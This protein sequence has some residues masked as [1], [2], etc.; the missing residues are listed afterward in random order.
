MPSTYEPIATTTLGSTATT[1]TFSSISSAYTDLIAICTVSGASPDDIRFR[2]NGDTNNSYSFTTLYGTGS[3][4]G[5][6]RGSNISSGQG[7]YYGT[8]STVLNATIQTIQFMNYSNITTYKTMIAR[9]ARSD[10]GTDATVSM[11]RNTAAINS[12]TFGM[13]GS[14]SLSFAVGSTISLYGIKAA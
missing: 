9:G 3:A 5:S 12:I 2:V 10:S 14:L 8:P 6:A 1:I 11:W 13:G 7:D 4:A